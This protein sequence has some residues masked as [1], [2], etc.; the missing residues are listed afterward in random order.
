M[1]G[2]PP[3]IQ[4]DLATL[5]PANVPADAATLVQVQERY[6]ELVQFANRAQQEQRLGT[7]LDRLGLQLTM[8]AISN[9]Q[10]LSFSGKAKDLLNFLSDI[11]KHIYLATGGQEDNDLRRAV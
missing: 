5:D 11:E 10:Q 8:Q 2:I 9:S 6:N 1:A 7:T 3:P 4:G